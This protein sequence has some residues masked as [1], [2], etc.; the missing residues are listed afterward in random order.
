MST[1]S[2]IQSSSSILKSKH[3]THFGISFRV[4][5]DFPHKNANRITWFFVIMGD[6]WWYLSAFKSNILVYQ[7]KKTCKFSARKNYVIIIIKISGWGS[8]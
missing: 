2:V 4:I 3:Y 6:Y 7:I 1:L 5:G 8:S